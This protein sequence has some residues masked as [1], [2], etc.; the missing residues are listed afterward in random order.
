[1]STMKLDIEKFDSKVNFG[2][3]KVNMKAI[4]IQLGMQKKAIKGVEKLPEG[5][6]VTRCE[7]MGRD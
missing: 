7:D 4:L 6:T 1:M 5:M 2:L 3:W